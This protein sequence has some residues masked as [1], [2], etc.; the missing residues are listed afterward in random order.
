[1]LK[2]NWYCS[3]HIK[4]KTDVL[5]K[6]KAFTGFWLIKQLILQ[7]TIGCGTGRYFEYLYYKRGS[8]Q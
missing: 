1:M 2:H 3:I 8:K 5:K 4:M 6:D 7:N